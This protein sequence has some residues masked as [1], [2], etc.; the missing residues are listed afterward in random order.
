MSSQKVVRFNPVSY[1]KKYDLSPEIRTSPTPVRTNRKQESLYTEHIRL[2]EELK[3]VEDAVTL[4]QRH[5]RG[6]LVR[7]NLDSKKR[8]LDSKKRKLDS[9]KRKLDDTGFDSH[10]IDGL[11]SEEENLL[12]FLPLWKTECSS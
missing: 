4:V 3:M 5:V 6:F 11:D 1:I 2:V 10:S 9:K 12:H 8:K 7:H